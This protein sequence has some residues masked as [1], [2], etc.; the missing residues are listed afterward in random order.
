MTRTVLSSMLI[1]LNALMC[2]NGIHAGGD[3]VTATD[4]HAINKKL[5][6]GLNLGNALEAPREGEWG[7]TLKAEYFRE[8]KAAGFNTVRLPVRW[9]AHAL[10]MAP[11]TI[12]AKF[13]ERVDWAIDQALANK[14]NIIVNVHHYGEIDAN[15]DEHLPRLV[16]LWTQIAE[17]YKDRPPEVVFE[18]LNEPHDKLTEAKWNAAIPTLLAVVRKMNPQRAIIVGP[19]Q[20]NSIRA[21]DKLELPADD[22]RLIVTVHYYDP[23][24]FTHQGASWAKGSNEWKGKTWTGTDAEQS[25]A[26]ASLTKAAEWAKSHDRPL[27][28]GEFGAYQE[29]DMASRV[30]WTR[31]ISREV[32]RLGSS[33]AYWEFC[34]GFGAFDPKTDTWREP[35]REALL[36]VTR[37]P[38]LPPQPSNPRNSE[39]AFLQLKDGRVLFVYTH[40]TG[41]GSDHAAAHLAARYSSD[42]GR[43]WTATDQLVLPNDAKMN[44]MSVSLLRLNTGEIALFYLRKNAL[45]DCRLYLRRSSDEGQTWGPPVLCIPDAGYFVVNN[46]RVIQLKSGRLVVPA[47]RRNIAGN[48]TPYPGVA[49]CYLSDDNGKT[50]RKSQTELQPP[51]VSK[52]GLQE[53]GLVELKDGK[54]M[55]LCRTDQGC[56]FRTYSSDGGEHWTDA[57]PSELRSPLSPASV[58]RI[59]K[60]GDLLLVWNDHSQIDAA[61]KDKRTPFTV[62]ISRDEGKTWEGIKN[63]EDDADGWYC[64]TAIDFVGNRVLLGHCA[65]DSQVGRL[66]RTQITLFDVDWLYK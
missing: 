14:L 51:Q 39:G 2:T 27:F 58:K 45:D 4:I 44:V 26:R 62:A 16:G 66:N 64:Y 60:T 13:A 63:L 17:R 36:E 30:R 65:G 5:G 50:W 8:I 18:L 59:P 57:E 34:S 7:V 15:P 11:Y 52:S 19:G 12:D 47:S 28:L 24:Q 55:M 35:L 46:D 6:R 40:F 56:Q 3:V 9:S 25:A 22:R 33:W 37:I 31:F 10:P 41:G 42:G 1:L 54:L 38:L 48:P 29:A 21:L 53:P 43:T 61:R 32:E 49:V 20:W 23:F